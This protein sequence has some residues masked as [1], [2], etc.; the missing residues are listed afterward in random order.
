[1]KIICVGGGPA[2]LYLAILMKRHDQRHDITVVERNSPGYTHG[3]GVVFWDN[4]L[5]TLQHS[6]AESARMISDSAKRW[7]SQVVEIQGRQA[8]ETS[9]YCGYS[10]GRQ[11]LLDILTE[12]ARELG[13][14]TEFE[15]EVTSLSELPGCDLLVACDGANSRVRQL[16]AGQFATKTHV[17]RNKYVWLATDKVFDSFTFAFARADP[18]WVWCHAYGVDSK[19]STFIVE[20]PPEVW[21]DLGFDAMSAEDTLTA[22]EDI[23]KRQLEGHRLFGRFR[24]GAAVPWLNFRSITNQNWHADKIVLMGDAAH[25][26]HFTI[27]SGTTL[28]VED[29][30]A[31]ASQLQGRGELHAALDAYAR[32]RQAAMLQLQS[33]A[34][35]S[36]QWF[37]SVSRYLELEPDQFFTLLLKRRSPLLR[38]LSPRLYL[39]ILRATEE[40]AALRELRRQIWPRARAFYNRRRAAS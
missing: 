12:R 1:M 19:F 17:G 34:R 9:E 13:V 10:I 21:A 23:F 30:V 6:D 14:R 35:L 8:V 7:A 29:A 39:G 4:L 20:C 25:T 28:A 27:G 3:W 11:R 31:L 24:D 32:G 38:H 18:G 16:N 26:T 22:L 5:E 37:E 36:A 40:N 33:E 15:R 2:G